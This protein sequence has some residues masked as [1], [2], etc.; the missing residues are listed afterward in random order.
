MSL[1]SPT[2]KTA[3]IYGF[4][5]LIATGSGLTAQIGYSVAAAKVSPDSVPTAIGFINVAQIGTI[6]IALSLSGSLF[7][8]VGFR[9]LSSAL[10]GYGF[11][12]A[13]L[14]DALAGAQ[15]TILQQGSETVVKLAIEAVVST[16]SRIFILII[17][18]GAVMLVSAVFMK[19]ERL[20]LNQAAAG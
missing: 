18:A 3:A 15:S 6:A 17:T 7:Q 19:R 4:E 5:I 16:I 9:K 14:R 11:D 13:A 10:A 20:Q 1:I 2:T 8:N 12:D